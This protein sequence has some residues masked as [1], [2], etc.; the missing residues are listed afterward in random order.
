MGYNNTDKYTHFAVNKQTNKIVNGWD[1]SGYDPSELRQFKKDY[2]IED[3]I[4]MEFNP[5]DYK[6]LTDRG[7]R[8]QGINPDDDMCWSNDG[9]NESKI[10]K[11][12]V[13]N[14]ADALNKLNALCKPL[15]PSEKDEYGISS[16]AISDDING[17]FIDYDNWNDYDAEPPVKSTWHGLYTLGYDLF[18]Y[19]LICVNRDGTVN[20][21]QSNHPDV[22]EIAAQIIPQDIW[23]KI[24]KDLLLTPHDF[25]DESKAKKHNSPKDY[26]SAMRKG[27]RDA[28]REKFGNGFKSKN[29]QHKTSKKDNMDRMKKISISDIEEAVMSAVEKMLKESAYAYGRQEYYS[30]PKNHELKSKSPLDSINKYEKPGNP[31]YDADGNLIGYKGDKQ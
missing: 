6:I 27:E 22:A 10:I 31:M 15:L 25:I 23:A 8:Q 29:K 14:L 28:E 3:L 5:N 17:L 24:Y 13:D 26:I 16:N 1:Y 2:F 19:D 12:S 21:E 7:C 30:G 4:D 18:N 11:E 20:I 9:I